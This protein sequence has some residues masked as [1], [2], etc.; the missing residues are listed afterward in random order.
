MHVQ[1]VQLYLKSVRRV[2]DLP[3]EIGDVVLQ[4]IDK[5]AH[6]LVGVLHPAASEVGQQLLGVL[7][8]AL[9]L[10]GNTAEWKK[11][12]KDQGQRESREQ[13]TKQF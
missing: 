1:G 4:C 12:D 8:Q 6:E 11:R 13:R 7:L 2:A 5:H 9:D 10:G 3:V